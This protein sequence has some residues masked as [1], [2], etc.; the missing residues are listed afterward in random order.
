MGSIPNINYGIVE[1]WNWISIWHI[2]RTLRLYLTCR[3]RG[4]NRKNLSYPMLGVGQDWISERIIHPTKALIPPGHGLFYP[5]QMRLN[6]PIQ[7]SYQ[8]VLRT[9]WEID[10]Y[11]VG[12]EHSFANFR[13]S[14]RFKQNTF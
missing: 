8:R 13:C 2:S 7:P 10:N 11:G 9:L 3:I 4:Q 12:I 6:N 5:V 1:Y 14:V